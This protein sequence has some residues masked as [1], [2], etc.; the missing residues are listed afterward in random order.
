LEEAEEYLP[1]VKAKPKFKKSTAGI[2]KRESTEESQEKQ[3]SVVIPAE[4][5]ENYPPALLI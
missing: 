3:N 4:K 2:K 5:A 1:P